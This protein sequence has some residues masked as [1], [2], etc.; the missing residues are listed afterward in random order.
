[1][2]PAG[3]GLKEYDKIIVGS[4][5][6]MERAQIASGRSRTFVTSMITDD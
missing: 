3:T 1:L 2:I 4:K 6:E 5:E